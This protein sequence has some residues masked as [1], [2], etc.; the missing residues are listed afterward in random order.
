M[1]W[2]AVFLFT[3]YIFVFFPFVVDRDVFVPLV[4]GGRGWQAVD[5][6]NGTPK[7]SGPSAPTSHYQ[8]SNSSTVFGSHHLPHFFNTPNSPDLSPIENCWRS[9]KQ[10]ITANL[11]ITGL[12]L[13]DLVLAGWERITKAQINKMVDSMVVRMQQVLESGRSDDRVVNLEVPSLQ[14]KFGLVAM[15]LEVMCT[16]FFV[17]RLGGISDLRK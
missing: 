15:Y 14:Y 16:V 9:V 13:R 11:S 12:G 6:K 17:N 2:L 3:F 8:F 1:V 5:K 7:A 10:W 4:G